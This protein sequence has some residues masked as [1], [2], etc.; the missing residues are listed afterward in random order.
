MDRKSLYNGMDPG[1]GARMRLTTSG[2]MTSVGDPTR[3]VC[4]EI[5]GGDI[6]VS[7]ERRPEEGTML[8][9]P[10]PGRGNLLMSHDAA[11]GPRVNR[12]LKSQEGRNRGTEE[13]EINGNSD[14]GGRR[15]EVRD[16]SPNQKEGDRKKAERNHGETS[17]ALE[18]RTVT[19]RHERKV[20]ETLEELMAT[21]AVER[22][23]RS[24]EKVQEEE[25]ATEARARVSEQQE[26]RG[27]GEERIKLAEEEEERRGRKR[28]DNQTGGRGRGTA[29]RT[30]QARKNGTTERAKRQR[31]ESQ[32]GG[33]KRETTHR[34]VAGEQKLTND[35][36]KLAR[37]GQTG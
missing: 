18:K 16:R 2:M 3:D 14:V 12:R 34:T 13:A 4:T 31:R 17:S 5:N 32:T 11:V 10:V 22:V 35:G 21:T 25:C 33:R 7:G 23:W 20:V 37:M 15:R 27:E 19:P 36:R 30:G 6:E 28:E 1:V 24:F 29:S 26:E 9:K 8:L